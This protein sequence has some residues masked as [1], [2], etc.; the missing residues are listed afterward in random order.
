MRATASRAA[1]R[2]GPRAALAACGFATR[3]W[4]TGTQLDHGRRIDATGRG[5]ESVCRAALGGRR[6]VGRFLRMAALSKNRSCVLRRTRLRGLR[7]PQLIAAIEL[8]TAIDEIRPQDTETAIQQPIAQSAE[9]SPMKSN[10]HGN[11][12]F[13]I[14]A[15]R[16]FSF[17]ATAGSREFAILAGTESSPAAACR[18]DLSTAAANRAAAAHDAALAVA[19]RAA[20]SPVRG[21][22]GAASSPA[23]RAW[24]GIEDGCAAESRETFCNILSATS[25]FCS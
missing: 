23:S 16:E 8:V 19:Q 6:R 1:T 13:G 25:A 10:R 17:Q 2:P 22:P 15:G 24:C 20:P 12:F 4:P 14:N 7:R 5:I 21:A 3:P 11:T 18:H 9:I